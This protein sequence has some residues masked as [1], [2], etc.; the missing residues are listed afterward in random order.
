MLLPILGIAGG[1]VVLTFASDQFV[2]G[3]ARLAA[4]LRLSAV[5]IGAVVIGFGTSA[6]E[7]IVSGLAA[8]QGSLDIA[9]GN[10]VGSNIANLSLVLGLASLVV[11]IAVASPT[12]RREI[13]ISLA[14]TVLFALL[15]QGGLSRTEGV[16]AALALAVA[17][18]WMLRSARGEDVELSAEVD[19]FLADETTVHTGHELA[20]TILGLAATLAAA[21]VLVLS[22]TRI[23]ADVGLA[24]GFVGLT[25]VAI[26]T[27]LPEL[28]TSLQAARKGETDLIV[29][30]LLGSNIFNSLGVVAVAALVGP[31]RLDDPALA[32]SA[33]ALMLA[34][35]GVAAVAMV[36]GRR[37]VRWEGLVLLVG[38]LA[39]V[40]FLA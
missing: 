21:Q 33:V 29:G 13:P 32:G 35:S 8:A 9:V 26:G 38:Y 30:N 3:A 22:A 16:I 18:G 2:L 34:V 40:P 15:V 12:I 23:A 1:L 4:R 11:P 5:V 25:I 19:E 14:A 39:V 27:S 6:P 7:M 31:G 24:E 17:L 36:T 10:V 20:R 28:A 37:V